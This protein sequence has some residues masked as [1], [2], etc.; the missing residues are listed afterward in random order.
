MASATIAPAASATLYRTIPMFTRSGPQ[1]GV[2][3]AWG[4][5][6]RACAGHPGVTEEQVLRSIGAADIEIECERAEAMVLA[7]HGDRLSQARKKLGLAV[8]EGPRGDA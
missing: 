8:D 4:F 7:G 2:C 5:P 6:C 1:C 3:S